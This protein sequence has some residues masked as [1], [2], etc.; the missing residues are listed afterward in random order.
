MSMENTRVL[1]VTDCNPQSQLFIDYIRQQLDCQVSALSTQ[2]S[3]EPRRS[4]V[5]SATLLKDART[6]DRFLE[7][8]GVDFQWRSPV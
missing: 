1:M 8:L 7:H 2:E 6:F 4:Q 3:F 5:P